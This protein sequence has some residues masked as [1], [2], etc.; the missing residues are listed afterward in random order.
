MQPQLSGVW[1]VVYGD[2]LKTKPQ[3]DG[4]FPATSVLRFGAE[5]KRLS[6]RWQYVCCVPAHVYNAMVIGW[7]AAVAEAEGIDETNDVLSVED[8]LALEG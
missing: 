2:D 7:D 3:A 8:I 6:E 1:Y 5:V 4:P